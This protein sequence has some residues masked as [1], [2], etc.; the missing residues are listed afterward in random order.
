MATVTLSEASRLTKLSKIE[1]ARAIKAGRLSATRA[2]TGGY[3]IDPAEL[4][5]EYQSRPPEAADATSEAL[6]RRWREVAELLRQ[7]D[8]TREDRPRWR[9][10][11]ERPALAAPA[12]R[13]WWRRLVG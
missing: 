1:L 2:E 8:D 3:Q 11:A 7:L 13:S 9:A 10:Q 5:R 12:S 6:R 4:S